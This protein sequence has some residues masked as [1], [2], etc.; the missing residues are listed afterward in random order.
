MFEGTA[1]SPSAMRRL[2]AQMIVGELDTATDGLAS[3][4]QR[5]APATGTNRTEYVRAL[6]EYRRE[7]GV[8]AQLDTVPG[9]AHDQLGV[10][11]A[12][13][14]FFRVPHCQGIWRYERR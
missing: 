13:M 11:P 3:A 10:L 12:V 8:G 6:Y 7:A 4:G 2:P 1:A 9:V 5:P 14:S